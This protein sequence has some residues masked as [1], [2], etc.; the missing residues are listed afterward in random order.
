MEKTIKKHY[1]G[2]RTYQNDYIAHYIVFLEKQIKNKKVINKII[3]L[4]NTYDNEKTFNN[5]QINKNNINNEINI[6]ILNYLLNNSKENHSLIKQLNSQF[7]QSYKT[8][9]SNT[10]R[11][12]N[13]I[14]SNMPRIPQTQEVLKVSNGRKTKRSFKLP[15]FFPKLQFTKKNRNRIE[16]PIS[17]RLQ[18]LPMR[19]T[20]QKV[21]QH[22][23]IRFSPNTEPVLTGKSPKP[24]S[25][26][27]NPMTLSGSP[28]LNFNIYPENTRRSQFRKPQFSSV[29]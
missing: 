13:Q 17:P 2:L 6:S 14:I 21:P 19:T 29:I 1:G 3:E 16:K 12:L 20:P 5:R 10:K 27:R 15:R 18:N 8:Y 22:P 25:S 28:A 4:L 11:N 26:P 9:I 23:L 7:E 24:S